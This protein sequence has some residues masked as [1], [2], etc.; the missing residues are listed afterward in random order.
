MKS[1]DVKIWAGIVT[2]NPN[3]HR[4]KENIESINNQVSNIVVFDNGSNNFDDIN[5]MVQ[6]YKKIVLIHSSKNKGL[7]YALNQICMK[8]FDEKVDWILLLDQDS[9][10]DSMCIEI[11]SEYFSL[12]QA[13]ILCPV[14]FDSRRRV[15]TPVKLEGYTEVDE[16]I[17]SGAVYNVSILKEM[18]F[19]DEWYFIDY[20][21]Y[22]YCISV[23]RKGYKIYQISKLLLDQE[24][25]T[26]E[27]VF[28]HDILLKIAKITK[29]EFFA[30]LSYRPVID[31]RRSYYT[32]RNRVY[33]IYKNRD[34]LNVAKEKWKE[35]FAN[36]RNII[37]IRDHIG[38]FKAIYSGVSDGRKRIKEME[39]NK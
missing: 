29:V 28:C 18:N 2:Y 27:P 12:K 17:Q 3:L 20:I 13:A 38:T 15:C 7:G 24:A 8:A 33:Y 22:D 32:A 39:N 23:R 6:Y 31:A 25:S 36:I 9:V 5:R 37:R 16:C 11:F 14:M 21:D 35:L 34:M 1:L 30:K 26:I 4:F 10:S 19:F